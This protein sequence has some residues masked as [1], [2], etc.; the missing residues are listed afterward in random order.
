M[1]AAQQAAT[2]APPEI[3]EREDIITG[4]EAVAQA[5]RLLDVDVF[6][7][8]PIRPYDSVMTAVSKMIANGE[9]DAEFIVAEF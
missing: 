5:L 2:S 6:A 9:M 4:C 8:Y 7:A 3:L 1:T